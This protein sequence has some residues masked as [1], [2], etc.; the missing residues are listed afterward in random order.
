M[1]RQHDVSVLAA[2]AL[3]DP[4]HHALAVD[5][6]NLERNHFGG[7]QSCPIGNTQRRF[8]FEPRRGIEEARYLLRTQHDRELAG[9]VDK[10][11]VLDDGVSLERD[12]EKEP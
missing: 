3:L 8:V 6:G 9:L 10:R 7:A 11:R 12:P 1:G 2:L 4:D 5:I